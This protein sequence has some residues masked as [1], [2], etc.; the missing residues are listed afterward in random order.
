MHQPKVISL[1]S[2]AGGLDYGLEA[3]GYQIAVANDIDPDSVATLRHNRPWPAHLGSIFELPSSELLA[4]AGLEAEQADLLVGGPPCQPFSK[5]GYWARGD[6]RRLGDPRANTLAAY[7]RVLADTRPHAFLLENVEGL[8]YAG[9]NEGLAFLLQ[10]IQRINIETGTHYLP[11]YAVLNAADFGVPQVRQRFFMVASRK[12]LP[13]KFPVSL[14]QI[15]PAERKRHAPDGTAHYRNAWDALADLAP[16]PDE[17][18]RLRGKWADLL[19]SIPEGQNYLWHT[20]RGGGL[21]LFGWRRRYWGFLLKLAKDRPSWTLQAQPGPAI[22]PFH[23]SNRRLSW[24][25][26]CRLQTFPNDV[27]IRGNRVSVQR[28]VGNAVPSLLAEVLGCEIRTQLLG[29]PAPAQTLQLLPPRRSTIPHQ[30]LVEPVP[31]RFSTYVGH[32]TPHPGTGQGHGARRRASE[33]RQEP[34]PAFV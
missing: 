1:F 32:H 27:Q 20:D 22:G 17:D 9:K 26:L 11:H 29:S 34:L 6:T 12:G 19:P 8:A 15:D 13:F 2:G 23:W 21:P 25:E 30:E 10:E 24:R 7:L 28:Q 16:E 3:A 4:L 31:A 18:L 5:S 33:P 14:T